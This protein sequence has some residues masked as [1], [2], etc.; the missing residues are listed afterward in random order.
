MRKWHD[1]KFFKF[2]ADLKFLNPFMGQEIFIVLKYSLLHLNV[3]IIDEVVGFFK[4]KTQ[5][6]IFPIELYANL[7]II[8][9][10]PLFTFS[11]L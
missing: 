2:F 9:L 5:H 10:N 1:G 11:V 6:T 7:V 4:K 8:N 3:K